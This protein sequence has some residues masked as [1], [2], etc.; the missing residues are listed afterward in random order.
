V[1][2]PASRA[3]EPPDRPRV[4]IAEDY[5]LI[6]ENIRR[7]IER[8]C[9]I[10]ATVED[11]ASA[12]AAV[13]SH[14][15]DVLLLDVSLPDM[16]GFAVLEQLASA[17]ATVRVVV[18]TAHADR[19]YVERAFELGAKGYV[20]KGKMWTDL[21]AAIREITRGGIY[22]SPLLEQRSAREP[23]VSEDLWR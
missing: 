18:I 5:V 19:S 1:N 10:L 8:Q 20:L 23:D 6:Q 17:S 21:P 16:S 14:S 4:I 3:A 13:R 2:H 7:L 15:P 11:G 9:E 12:L 22:K